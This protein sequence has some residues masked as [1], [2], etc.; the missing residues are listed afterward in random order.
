MD[1]IFIGW[2]RAANEW[3]VAATQ[4]P[5]DEFVGIHLATA[6][7]DL[8]ERFKP[9]HADYNRDVPRHFTR[10]ERPVFQYGLS[11]NVQM[12]FG[13]HAFGG[14][15]ETSGHELGI[16]IQAVIK[17]PGSYIERVYVADGRAIV[18]VDIVQQA[19]PV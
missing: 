2:R 18:G 4:G 14:G 8:A 16:N 15:G 19:K 1:A 9:R 5:L 10:L 6:F 7:D 13:N 11:Q 17:L 3:Q 12:G